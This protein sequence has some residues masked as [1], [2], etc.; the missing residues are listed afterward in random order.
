[1]SKHLIILLDACRY[2]ALKNELPKYTR[3]FILFPVYSGS[4]N[5]PTFYK[6]ITN[7][8]D[9]V[10]LTAN[11]TPFYHK[12]EHKWKRVIHTKSIDPMDNLKECIELLKSE[13]K[14]FLHLIPPHVPW[15][16]AEGRNVYKA[17]MERLNFSMELKQERRNFGPIGIESQVYQSI[18]KKEA[19]KYYLENLDYAL[20]AIFKYHAK[21]PK[22]F[23]ITADHGE[24]LGEDNLWGHSFRKCN[25]H[26]LRVIPIAII[27]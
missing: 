21:L 13:D 8:E 4:H 14:V 23:V 20:S 11:P 12:Q 15:Q 16:G 9:F 27:Y 3:N 22:P 26:T 1:V 25:H 18:G 5:T 19:Y 17:L 24:L 6:N 7:V 10:L 2:D